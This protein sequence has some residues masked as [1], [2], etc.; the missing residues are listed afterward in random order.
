MYYQHP[1]G[2]LETGLKE[3]L[4]DEDFQEI[5]NFVNFIVVFNVFIE[6]EV[7]WTEFNV[8]YHVVNL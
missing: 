4:V 5:S 6:M 1:D 3:L 7:L 2:D 8:V